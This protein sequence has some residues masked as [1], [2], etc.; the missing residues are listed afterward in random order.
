MSK[1]IYCTEV[2]EM[3]EL[4]TLISKEQLEAS[5]RLLQYAIGEYYNLFYSD[6]KNDIMMDVCKHKIEQEKANLFNLIAL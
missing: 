2:K 3:V 6:D 4:N 1:I 5:I